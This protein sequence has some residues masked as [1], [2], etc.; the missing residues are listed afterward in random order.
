MSD[1][2]FS[3]EYLDDFFPLSIRKLILDYVYFEWAKIVFDNSKYSSVNI[4]D[5]IL[6]IGRNP[7]C[8]I[9]VDHPFISDFNCII[10]NKN[11]NQIILQIKVRM[12]LG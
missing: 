1:P 12:E 7:K 3:M 5:S 9:Q 11:S 10:Q 2:S 4:V 6:T 8:T